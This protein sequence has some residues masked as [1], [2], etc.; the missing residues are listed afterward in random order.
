MKTGGRDQGGPA[1]SGPRRHT[2]TT[3]P[4][5]PGLKMTGL[6]IGKNP[7]ISYVSRYVSQFDTYPDTYH[8]A[9]LIT[10]RHVSRYAPQYDTYYDTHH[11]SIH[12]AMR[13]II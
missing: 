7:T 12:I 13:I 1:G 11:N 10:I 5:G 9:I 6:R 4:T 3:P 8:G 2:G